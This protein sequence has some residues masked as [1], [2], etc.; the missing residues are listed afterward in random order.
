MT[1]RATGNAVS[2]KSEVIE[3]KDLTPEERERQWLK[4]CRKW[5]LNRPEEVLQAMAKI[6]R[7]YCAGHIGEQRYKM[8]MAGLKEIRSGREAEAARRTMQEMGIPFSGMVL[9]GP[10]EQQRSDDR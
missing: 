4:R 5:S 1:Q 2:E 3:A 7:A 6:W 10:G 8:L 9:I